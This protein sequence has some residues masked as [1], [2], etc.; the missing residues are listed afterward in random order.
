MKHTS[1]I[2]AFF[3]IGFIQVV[4]AVSPTAT[5]SATPTETKSQK[6]EDL[7]DR[8]ATKVA[9]LNTTERRAIY[10]TVKSTSISTITVET[11]TKDV[12]IELTDDIKVF[13]ML[14]GKRTEL[15]I[16]NVEKG[17]VVTVFGQYDTAVEILKAKV[18]FI[19]G[20]GD[21]QRIFG[22]IT[23]AKKADYTLTV[24]TG[25]GKSFVVDFETITK[26]S[27]W[28]SDKGIEK[29]GFSKLLVGDTVT[30]LGTP[31][32]KKDNRLSALRILDLGNLSGEKPATTPTPT[33]KGEATASSAKA[34]ATPT[35]SPTPT[36]K[37]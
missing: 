32:A 28:S 33:E 11:T 19:Q 34:T 8:L 3:I 29:A 36:P 9:E 27:T 15:K 30:I 2:L 21:T 7:K 20:T 14:K 1:L 18:I 22:T 16:E 6:L 17:D 23:D 24:E 37:P 26:T 12:K 35:K 5:P 13:Q 4:N 10:G 31:V 25:N